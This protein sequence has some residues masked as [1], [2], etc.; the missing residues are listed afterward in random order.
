MATR[1][2]SVLALV[3]L[4]LLSALGVSA[5]DCTRGVRCGIVPWSYPALPI[6]LTP[7]PFPTVVYTPGPTATP[8][9]TGQA[10]LFQVQATPTPVY[11]PTAAPTPASTNYSDKVRLFSPLAYW[12]LED[13]SIATS[14]VDVMRGLNGTI[15]GVQMQGD[16]FP[17][18]ALVARFDGVND[19]IGLPS[20]SLGGQMNWSAGSI[21]VWLKVGN[22]SEWASGTQRG[23]FSITKADGQ[24][25]IWKSAV[26]TLTATFQRGGVTENLSITTSSSQWIF[27]SVSWDARG[28]YFRAGGQ[29]LSRA[30]PGGFGLN[31]AEAA[32]GRRPFGVGYWFGGIAHAAVFRRALTVNDWTSLEQVNLT[33]P[34]NPVNCVEDT[35][36]TSPIDLSPINHVLQAAEAVG[37]P[38]APINVNQAYD[39]YGNALNFFSIMRGVSAADIG[40]FTAVLVVLFASFGLHAGMFALKAGAPLAATLVGAVRKLVGIVL[41]FLPG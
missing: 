15:N 30:M 13:P 3:A 19:F 25:T 39:L 5:Q 24:I 31:L 38:G 18:A 23:V 28:F 8:L 33:M 37:T 32:I 35:G 26:N 27:A 12:P 20:A 16:S 22:V 11:C 7:T 9:P 29:T 40:P 2:I 1:R 4:M 6:L 41:D 14:A 36:S 10:G 21:M 34:G 17:P